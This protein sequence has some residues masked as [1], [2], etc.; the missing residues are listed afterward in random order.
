MVSTEFKAALSMNEY[1]AETASTAIY[2]W[3]V[4]Y[5]ALGLSNEAGEVG[6]KLKKLIR[7][8]GLK[9]DG[10]DNLTDK[11]RA[12][13]GSELGDVLWYIAALARDLGLSLN[14]VAH[15]NLE[16]LSDRKARGKIGG[17]GDDR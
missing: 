11:Q 3:R 15:M 13:I 10:T 5:P 1:Q 12:D 8:E 9:F 16:K 7:D 14:E 17:S 2:K 4:I 6:G